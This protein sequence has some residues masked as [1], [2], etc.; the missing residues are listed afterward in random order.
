M[1][2]QDSSDLAKKEIGIYKILEG[3]FQ[4]RVVLEVEVWPLQMMI[5]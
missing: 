5:N 2:G 3:A 4:R 1:F